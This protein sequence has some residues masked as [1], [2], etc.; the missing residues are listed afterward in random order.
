MPKKNNK[1]K[2]I[3]IIEDEEFLM[4]MYRLKFER[5]GYEI[6]AAIDGKKGLEIAKKE[7][8]G[9]ILLDLVLPVMNGFE[10][11]EKLKADPDTVDIKVVI[12]SNLGQDEEISKGI[13]KGAVGYLVKSNMT[14]AQILDYVKNL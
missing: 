8:P 10:V 12:L 2:R 5:E 3:L 4:D 9:I 11:L 7:K 6:L 13:S 14:P 1:S